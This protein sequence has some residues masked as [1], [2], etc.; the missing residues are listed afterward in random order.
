MAKLIYS[1]IASLDCFVEDSDGEF[2]WAEPTEEVFAF[3]NQLERP[4]GTYLYGRRMY[5]TMVYWESHDADFS[6]SVER[7]FA[8]IWRAATKIVYSSTLTSTSSKRTSIEPEF[9]AASIIRMKETLSHDFSINGAELASHALRV[10]LVDEVQLF[11][12]PIVVGAGKPAFPNDA[13]V[14]FELLE[15]R[16]FAN[17]QVFLRYAVLK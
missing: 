8:E 15:Q 7:E 5:E 1:T 3:I 10:G 14:A 2:A 17:G 11:L 16:R 13:H 6:R 4:I 12:M 9:N